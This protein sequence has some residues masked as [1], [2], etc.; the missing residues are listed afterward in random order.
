M[1]TTLMM[2]VLAMF[3]LSSC[4]AVKRIAPSVS[5][6]V[7]S[8]FHLYLLVG[9]SN[10]AG[11]G[12]LDSISNIADPKI[13][14]LDSSAQWLPAVDPIHFDKSVAGVGLGISFAKAMLAASQD[15]LI[16]I[17]LIPCAVGGTSIERWFAGE[18]DP[19]TKAYPYDEAINRANIAMKDGVLK[20]ILW[21]QGE[22]NNTKERATGYLEKQRS[23]IRHFRKD[24]GADLPFVL[25]E[26]GH[27]KKVQLINEI[28]RTVP[29]IVPNVGVV[30]AEGLT[31]IGDGTH[32]DAASARELGRRYAEAIRKLYIEDYEHR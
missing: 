25:G 7:D 17:G 13:L 2:A 30:T 8:N 21:H 12:K 16:R 3:F 1:K 23:V 29:N 15:T 32:F 26:I 14:M 5:T 10:M 24:L 22:G 28:I 4:T 31:D 18:R 19:V 6:P 11:R 20:G 27:F 9:Q